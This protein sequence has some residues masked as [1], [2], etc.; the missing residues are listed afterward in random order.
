LT[1]YIDTVQSTNYTYK[2]NYKNYPQQTWTSRGHDNFSKAI[3]VNNRNCIST[4]DN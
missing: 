4:I 3:E 2:Q 1:A